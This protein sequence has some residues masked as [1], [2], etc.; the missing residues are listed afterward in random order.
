ML[1][2]AL[3][4]VA[5]ATES[6]LEL[7]NPGLNIATSFVDGI[8]RHIISAKPG[9]EVPPIRI[10]ATSEDDAIA[11]ND[12]LNKGLPFKSKSPFLLDSP[13]PIIE[14][15]EVILSFD[16][17]NKRDAEIRL[18][19][20][21]DPQ[22]EILLPGV[23]RSGITQF[24]LRANLAGI[25]K[26]EF[27]HEIEDFKPTQNASFGIEL[28][29]LKGWEGKEIG[30]LPHFSKVAKLCR[31]LSCPN[32]GME[33][34]VEGQALSK[35]N[36]PTLAPG[37]IIALFDDIQQ[38]VT[39]ARNLKIQVFFDCEK[40]SLLDCEA[41]RKINSL[42]FAGTLIEILES[43]D[44]FNLE[45]SDCKF[46]ARYRSLGTL[47]VVHA[48]HEIEF[49]GNTIQMPPLSIMLGKTLYEV[50]KKKKNSTTVRISQ[51]IGAT[52]M[53]RMDSPPVVKEPR[54]DDSDS[55]ASHSSAD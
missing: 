10:L 54:R 44:E 1:Q 11:L 36:N 55:G 37:N 50:I 35:Y 14:S 38:V 3:P 52:R 8:V 20:T 53:I 18:F 41:I 5:K 32:L 13:F 15:T 29:S 4:N 27:S 45:L 23:F 46:P 7:Q 26:I 16:P 48:S 12:T 31:I 2:N 9:V 47:Q 28:D 42:W 6:I 33:V 19:N 17:V 40:F 39:L 22:D 43:S 30:N 24:S 49:F 34:I 21:E 25:L 51:P